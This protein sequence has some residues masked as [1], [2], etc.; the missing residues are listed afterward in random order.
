VD[1]ILRAESGR[2]DHE[3]FMQIVQQLSFSANWWPS[4]NIICDF[5]EAKLAF[6]SMEEL[7][8]IAVE[9]TQY[10]SVLTNKIAH[11]S[12]PDSAQIQIARRLENIL[13]LKGFFYK[14]F[15][16]IDDARTWASN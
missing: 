4:R 7:L 15:C 5:R 12:S 2:I 3:R 1:L 11:V 8:G 10:R 6:E 13:L 9:M 14:C 16:N